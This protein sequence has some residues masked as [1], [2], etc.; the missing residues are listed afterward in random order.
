MRYGNKRVIIGSTPKMGTG[1]NIQERLVAL[2]HVD[3]HIDPRTLNK[4]K[5]GF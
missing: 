5:V 3:C 2:D 1:T 4:G